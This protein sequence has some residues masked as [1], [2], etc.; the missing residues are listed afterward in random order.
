M[1]C[2]VSFAICGLRVKA[3]IRISNELNVWTFA[4]LNAFKRIPITDIW[5]GHAWDWDT[6]S[7]RSSA[8]I[9]LVAWSQY[10]GNFSLSLKWIVLQKRLSHP[11]EY[12]NPKLSA[13]DKTRQLRSETCR[14]WRTPLAACAQWSMPRMRP[15]QES[16]CREQQRGE[17]G[18]RGSSIQKFARSCEN[19]PR[20]SSILRWSQWLNRDPNDRQ[21]I[22]VA[23]IPQLQTNL[24]SSAVHMAVLNHCMKESAH[25]DQAFGWRWRGWV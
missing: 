6:F 25:M 16:V 9:M 5:T 12:Q 20:I 8:P 15:I 18:E 10:C 11:L 23:P 24:L 21:S 14:T 13:L 19:F 3:P 7:R 4:L 1:V 22:H 2:E 17:R